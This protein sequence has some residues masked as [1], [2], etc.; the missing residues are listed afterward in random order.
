MGEPCASHCTAAVHPLRDDLPVVPH[1]ILGSNP[2]HAMQARAGS[3]EWHGPPCKD[4]RTT[5]VIGPH[6]A[7]KGA[8]SCQPRLRSLATIVRWTSACTGVAVAIAAIFGF[9]TARELVNQGSDQ[10]RWLA[11]G[12]LVWDVVVQPTTRVKETLHT[13]RLPTGTGRWLN[14]VPRPGPVLRCHSAVHY[15]CG[16]PDPRGGAAAGLHQ[17]PVAGP[18]LGAAVGCG[19]CAYEPVAVCD[20]SPYNVIIVHVEIALL[21][22]S[23]TAS[24]VGIRGRKSCAHGFQPCRFVPLWPPAVRFLIDLVRARDAVFYISLLY[25]CAGCPSS[26]I[27]G[28]T[29]WNV[30]CLLH[31]RPGCTALDVDCLRC[32]SAF[33]S[34]FS[35]PS[36]QRL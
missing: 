8:M 36:Y 27:P 2:H 34:S 22:L 26:L 4:P 6:D 9:D 13:P 21:V 16:R 30:V 32:W 28:S 29:D 14:D 10:V 19:R 24:G 18:C 11:A 25:C 17:A 7:A 3:S 35:R 31:F 5:S 20:D 15:L 1:A 23:L 12:T 33:A